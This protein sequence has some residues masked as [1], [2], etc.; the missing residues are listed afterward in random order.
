MIAEGL[1]QNGHE[2]RI[3][4]L[5]GRKPD[6][7][8][9][10]GPGEMV[11]APAIS[12]FVRRPK[13]IWLIAMLTYKLKMPP[14][15]A[16]FVLTGSRIK[17]DFDWAH[18]IIY[19]FPFVFPQKRP[20]KPAIFNS[21]N[22]ESRLYPG[23]GFLTKLISKWVRNRE[24]QASL[25]AQYQAVSSAEELEFFKNFKSPDTIFLVPNCVDEKRFANIQLHRASLRESLHIRPSTQVLFFAASAYGPN[26]A[27]FEFLLEFSRKYNDLLQENNIV[28]LISGSVTK[29]VI[30]EPSFI[31]T[32]PVPQIEPYFGAADWAV[33]PI[34]HGSGT[35]I[36]LAEMIA[37]RLPV[38]TTG[39]GAR[40]FDLQDEKSAIFFDKETLAHKIKS[41]TQYN[42]Q[43]LID[44]ARTSNLKFLQP[45]AA[46]KRIASISPEATASLR[47]LKKVP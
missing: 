43:N 28:F 31:S 44:L 4:S 7:L 17:N 27:G 15:W 26:Y 1:V 11:V 33:N 13:I 21:H 2:V 30:K 9:G 16:S 38:L 37:A 46:V 22:V 25:K 35:S 3:H 45:V 23:E 12:E 40:G 8:K 10:A 34:F 19:D 47:E 24:I 36:K 14:F 20:D 41:L 42:R 32:G 5:I 6:M 29:N 18:V 39:I